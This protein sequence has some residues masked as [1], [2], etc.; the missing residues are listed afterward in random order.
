LLNR[1]IMK[2]KPM[3]LLV[4]YDG[5]PGA[6]AALEDLQHAGLPSQAQ[7]EVLVISVA[8]VLVPPSEGLATTPIPQSATSAY[9]PSVAGVIAAS[10]QARDRAMQ[11][12]DEMQTVATK[13]SERLNALFPNWVVRG[14]AYADSPAWGVLKKEEEWQPDLTLVGADSGATLEKMFFGNVAQKIVTQVKGSVRV[15]RTSNQ[16]GSTPVR[17]LVGVDGSPDAQGALDVLCTRSF[18]QGSEVRVVTVLDARMNKGSAMLLPALARWAG[19]GDRSGENKSED[20]EFA[21]VTDMT[22]AAVAQLRAAGLEASATVQKGDSKRVLLHEAEHWKADCIFIGAKGLLGSSGLQNLE[23]FFL[24][25][26]AT[27]VAS[28]APCS[29][30]ITRSFECSEV[31][32]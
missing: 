27:V 28:R 25:S 3:K 22:E 8:D 15:G 2:N 11:A 7:V 23:R 14:E 29:V 31:K 1:I 12:V 9:S 4:A 30:E 24:G 18:P 32:P 21:W 17:L 26:T 16:D 20:G 5:S 13:G 10:Q 19:E 6:D